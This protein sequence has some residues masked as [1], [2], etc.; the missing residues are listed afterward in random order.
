MYRLAVVA[1][2][3]VCSFASSALFAEEAVEPAGEA[4]AAIP[5]PPADAPAPAVAPYP[6]EVRSEF[7]TSCVDSGGPEPVCSCVL[8][9]IERSWTVEQL[10]NNE[11]D[12]AWIIDTTNVCM[13]PFLADLLADQPPME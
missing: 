6:E 3:A 5:A 13:E 12:E 8:A 10:A 11:V 7:M 2:L 1:T 9:Q 4:P